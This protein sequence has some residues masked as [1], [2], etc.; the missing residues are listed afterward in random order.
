ML[1]FDD[2]GLEILIALSNIT[3]R[4]LAEDKRAR[5]TISKRSNLRAALK[6]RFTF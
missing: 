2:V 6:F 1:L 4:V 5:I 3:R